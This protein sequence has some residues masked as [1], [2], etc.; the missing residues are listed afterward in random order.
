MNVVPFVLEIWKKNKVNPSAYSPIGSEDFLG[1][2]R[3]NLKS[4]PELI[5]NPEA[6][7][8]NIYPTMLVEGE[9]PIWDPSTNRNIGICNLSFAFGTVK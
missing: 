7:A 2:V 6:F 5:V 4:I 9:M 3:L 1:L 8:S